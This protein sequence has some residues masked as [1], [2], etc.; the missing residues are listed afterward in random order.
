M[1]NSL[2]LVQGLLYPHVHAAF[3]PARGHLI[4]VILD[5]PVFPRPEVHNTE[6]TLVYTVRGENHSW[7]PAL[8]KTNE[9]D[10]EIF[11]R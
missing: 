4:A 9:K 1:P 7:G 11:V 3:H 5:L 6:A 10:K 2:L 8:S